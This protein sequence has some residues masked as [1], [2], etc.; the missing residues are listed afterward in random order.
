MEFFDCNV[1]YG[2]STGTDVFQPA[3]TVEALRT[4]LRRGGVQRAVVNRNEQATSST[5]LVNGM[6]AED[7]APHDELYGVW[8]IVPSHTGELPP[9][10]ELL[11]RMKAQRII[12][13]RLLP[14]RSRFLVKE[15]VLR[16]WLQ[17][18]V[19]HR[20]PVFVNTAHG[21]TLEQLA[22]LLERVPELTVVLTFDNCWPS[23]RLLRPFV[24]EFP[25]VHLDLTNMLTDG[26]IESF[27][28]VY[29]AS[30]LL[31]GSGFPIGYFGANM[32]MVK[33]AQIPEADREAIAGGN[34]ARLVK[35]V[36]G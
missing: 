33:H 14:A 24:A 31:Y 10:E 29:G 6:L 17:T 12:G 15:F 1:T 26:G 22:D 32:L 7:I 11:A 5:L 9:P 36:L 23:D 25:S 27:V 34:M 19:A 16:D 8:G 21:T 18:A 4:E 35:E 28:E 3:E 2:A 30:R 13:W 20:V